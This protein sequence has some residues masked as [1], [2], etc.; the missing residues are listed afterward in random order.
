[1]SISDP[2]YKS[3]KIPLPTL[4]GYYIVVAIVVLIF[5]IIPKRRWVNKYEYLDLLS[6]TEW[7]EGRVIMSQMEKLKRGRINGVSFYADM[8]ELVREELIVE[9]LIPSA[10]PRLKICEFKLTEGGI[11]RRLDEH[12]RD[13]GKDPVLEPGLVESPKSFVT[14]PG[15]D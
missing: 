7:K 12:Q 11:R 10:T 5:L 15:K 1:M 4:M 13:S 14:K 6:H 8:A 3:Y 2:C 9:R